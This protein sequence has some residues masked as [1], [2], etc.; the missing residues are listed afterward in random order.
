MLCFIESFDVYGDNPTVED[1]RD[2]LERKWN[3][4][5]LDSYGEVSLV[6]GCQGGR[7]LFLGPTDRATN[8]RLVKNIEPQT[9]VVVG[10]FMQPKSIHYVNSSSF[11][12]IKSEYNTHANLVLTQDGT[13]QIYT[14]GTS[15]SYLRE[16]T[17]SILPNGTWTYV[18]FALEISNSGKYELRFD[19]ETVAQ[20]DGVDTQD[21]DDYATCV[22]FYTYYNAYY[23]DDIYI[24]GGQNGLF[25]F[26]G[27]SKVSAYFPDTDIVA[28]WS[29]SS[30]VS[31]YALVD[32][33]APDLTTY[34]FT[35]T[36]GNT[37]LFRV[38]PSDLLPD[39]NGVQLCAEG[40]IAGTVPKGFKA[41]IKNGDDTVTTTRHLID[42]TYSTMLVVAEK[43]PGATEDWTLSDFSTVSFG[44]EKVS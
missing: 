5:V 26:L 2:Y 6:E 41:T 38:A 19:G 11:L 24:L 3:N 33:A 15:S 22:A 17:T 9:K 36:T 21:D 14:A 13:V 32:S 16:T 25:D 29:C 37:D 23:L 20:G 40:S 35:D 8:I 44:I 28:E 7:A 42:T 31:H 10:F 43:P 27:P 18:E 39:I 30:G 1:L 4:V 34:I 12:Q